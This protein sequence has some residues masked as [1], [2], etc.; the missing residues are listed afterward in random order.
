MTFTCS[1]I[2]PK[3]TDMVS[4]AI[5]GP[6]VGGEHMR[7]SR[8]AWPLQ[9]QDPCLTAIKDLTLS[10]YVPAV[11]GDASFC[12]VTAYISIICVIA[13]DRLAFR[14]N[15]NCPTCNC[16][17]KRGSNFYCYSDAQ[18]YFPLVSTA[19]SYLF[20]PTVDNLLRVK[21]RLLGTCCSGRH[22][23]SY[24]VLNFK[25]SRLHSTDGAWA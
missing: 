7:R 17:F 16:G 12:W 8:P 2:I 4:L 1:K 3:A 14:K 5:F 18:P 24:T 11:S 15:T 21:V 6:Y 13:T 23:C 25:A 9:F 22:V 10:I 20:P 19:I